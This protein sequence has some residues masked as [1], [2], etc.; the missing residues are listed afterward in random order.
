MMNLVESPACRCPVTFPVEKQPKGRY[1]VGEKVLY[2]RMLNERHVMVRVGGGW[3]T[4]MGYLTKHDPCRGG[5]ASRGPP[6]AR[7][8]RAK[9]PRVKDP[10]PDSYMVVGAHCRGKK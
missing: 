7:V 5:P 6:E 2:V 1:R 9:T 3:E 4:F 8:I 10:S